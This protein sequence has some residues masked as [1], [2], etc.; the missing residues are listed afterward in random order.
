[1]AATSSW[2]FRFSRNV[3]L[4]LVPCFLFW[5]VLTGFYNRFLTVS[6]QNLLH[7]GESPNVTQLLKEDLHYIGVSRSDFPPGKG[8]LYRIRVTDVHFHLYLLFARFLAVPDVPLK[9]RLSALGWAWLVAVF[10]EITDLFLW[11]KFVYATQLGSWSAE[12]YSS[13][14]QNFWGLGKHVFDLPLKLALPFALWM[15]FFYRRLPFFA[16]RSASS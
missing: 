5:S 16:Q 12:H 8:V 11:V 3:L 13:F 1:M 6:A 4:W 14:G 2:A 15:A 10:F 9:E 7:L